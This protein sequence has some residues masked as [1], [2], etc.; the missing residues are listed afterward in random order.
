MTRGRIVTFYSFKGGVGR[1]FALANCA[2]RWGLLGRRVLVVDWDL[3]SPGL[4]HYFRPF[5]RSGH[6]DRRGVID[7]FSA[8]QTGTERLSGAVAELAKALDDGD[9]KTAAA[10]FDD[11]LSPAPFVERMNFDPD[12]VESDGEAFERAN[13]RLRGVDIHIMAAGRQDDLYATRVSSFDWR[14]FVGDR[15]GRAVL[16]AFRNWAAFNYD[17]VLIDSRTGF[18]DIPAL[19]TRLLPDLVAMCFAPNRQNI[20]GVAEMA[21]LLTAIDQES[22]G[23]RGRPAV[24]PLMTRTDTGED[25]GDA[26]AFAS[27]RL[28]TVLHRREHEVRASLEALRVPIVPGL[29]LAERLAWLSRVGG[30]GQLAERFGEIVDVVD[31]RLG[32]REGTEFPVLAKELPAPPSYQS[33]YDSVIRLIDWRERHIENVAEAGDVEAVLDFVDEVLTFSPLRDGASD[34]PSEGVTELRT[35]VRV[36]AAAFRAMSPHRGVGAAH[37][38][39]DRPRDPATRRDR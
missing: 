19:C 21:E 10:I 3:T 31:E 30:A 27:R 33:W 35:I 38:S 18:D 17:I 36:V 4:H 37:G 39:L 14:G 24:L 20:E 23:T 28:A 2:L 9:R 25:A 8:I 22:F 11:V 32:P 15:N 7:Y 6:A 29:Q 16:E 13:E 34:D 12:D 5:L 26:V 1:T